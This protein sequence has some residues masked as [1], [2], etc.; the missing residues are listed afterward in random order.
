MLP[1]S[2]VTGWT[3]KKNGSSDTVTANSR[4]G[5]NSFAA[6][7][8]SAFTGGD[9][10]LFSYSQTGNTTSDNGVGGATTNNQEVL[11][12]TDASCTNITAGGGPTLAYT[13]GRWYLLQGATDT[14][15]VPKGAADANV[16]VAPGAKLNLRWKVKN[17]GADTSLNPRIRV[18]Y[19]GGG[20]V[21]L[22]SSYVNAVKAL[23][24]GA[25]LGTVM[26]DSSPMTQDQL[27]SDVANIACTYI[28]NPVSAPNLSLT[29]NTETECG[30][31]I[32]FDTSAVA[33]KQYDFKIYT[34]TGTAISG[35]PISAII[36]G[37][38]SQH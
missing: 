9:T 29:T 23:G 24:S 6:T 21:E 10:C 19:D 7:L 25:Q 30:A 32:D 18:S 5:T 13:H 35:G 15:W 36:G 8:T 27:T 12:F 16:T 34:D 17:T 31:A 33:G 1:V 38:S 26:S 28:R 37:Y 20:Y 11:A 4:S 3:F 22:T 14:A 2:S